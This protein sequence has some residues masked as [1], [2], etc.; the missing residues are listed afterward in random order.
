MQN[1]LSQRTSNVFRALVLGSFMIGY[2]ACQKADPTPVG[3]TTIVQP[4]TP[5]PSGPSGPT[6]S[7]TG[8]VNSSGTMNFTGT[9]S[10]GGG[11]TTITG[12]NTYYTIKLNFPSPT[13]PGHYTL[14]FSASYTASVYDGT[15]TYLVNPTYGS[16]NLTIDSIS[17]GYY[18]G[19]F[20]FI[21]EDPSFDSESANGNFTKI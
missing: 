21:G 15:N 6:T 7:F 5:G 8:S 11:T 9:K 17:S 3:I 18:Y 14:G 19:S 13:G 1:L 10:S 20:N 16:G 12:T 2:T 4:G